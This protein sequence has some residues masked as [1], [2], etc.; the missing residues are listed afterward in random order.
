[1]NDKN[2]EAALEDA[3]VPA[4]VCSLVH[5]TGDA[6]L[7]KP[8][9]RPTYQL[10]DRANIGL[11]AETIGDIRAT[12]P[13]DAKAYSSVGLSRLTRY[14]YRV[15]AVNAAGVSAWSNTASARTSLF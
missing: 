3:H 10:M 1:M 12:L 6:S 8:E 9:W 4:L 2:L 7:L 15:R 14:T 5:I 11:S 13:A